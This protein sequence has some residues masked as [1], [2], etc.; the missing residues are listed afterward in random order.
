MGFIAVRALPTLSLPVLQVSVIKLPD[1]TFEHATQAGG[2]E[3]IATLADGSPLPS[4]ISFDGQSG[5][6]TL[7]PPA[8]TSE[9]V[10]V[11]VTARDHVGRTASTGMV[12]NIH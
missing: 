2:F 9:A 1:D 5:T 8:G 7:K 10:S 12:L 6:F 3:L 4:W 11:V